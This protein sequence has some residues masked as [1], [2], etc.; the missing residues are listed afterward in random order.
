M[1][2]DG[3]HL[4]EDAPPMM[5]RGVRG[6][7]TVTENTGE[8]IL[9]ATREMLFL[10]IRA[11]GMRPEDVASAYFTTTT[12]LDAT[13]PARGE[14]WPGTGALAASITEAAGK[15]PVSIGKPRAFMLELGM[16]MLQASPQRT[17]MIGDRLDSDIQAGR[18]AGVDTLLVLSGVAGAEESDAADIEATYTV[19]G[20]R[21]LL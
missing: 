19:E 10:I 11:N 12:D 1:N 17:L 6:A 4:S 21:D 2:T 14:Q 9:S 15:E 3:H 5:C 18:R 13:Y 7:T 20:L 16:Q 8:A